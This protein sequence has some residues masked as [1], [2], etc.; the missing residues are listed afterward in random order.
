[1]SGIKSDGITYRRLVK[2]AVYRLA[3]VTVCTLSDIA[4]FICNR[5]YFCAAILLKCSKVCC[6]V[7]LGCCLP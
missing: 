4:Q 1:M 7:S 6:V 5:A 3:V 2:F